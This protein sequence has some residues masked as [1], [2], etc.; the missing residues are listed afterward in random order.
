M[1][2]QA[3]PGVS[4]P[5][6]GAVG[7]YFSHDQAMASR[8]DGMPLPGAG[9]GPNGAG[10]HGH[11]AGAT[12]GRYGQGAPP[13]NSRPAGGGDSEGEHSDEDNSA[14][15]GGGSGDEMLSDPKM[16]AKGP[17][18]QLTAGPRAPLSPI[19]PAGGAAPAAR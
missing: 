13:L 1:H 2:G 7:S 6:Q 10:P 18:G 16:A 4:P 8:L 5:S 15:G 12:P 9:A 14:G 19:P 17:V 11:Y 3:Q